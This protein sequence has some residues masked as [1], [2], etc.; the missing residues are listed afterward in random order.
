MLKSHHSIQRVEFSTYYLNSIDLFKA[1]FA[2]TC[3][4]LFEK[5]GIR[6]VKRPKFARYDLNYVNYSDHCG[7][8]II[9]VWTAITNNR[10]GFLA[11]LA[12]RVNGCTYAEILDTFRVNLIKQNFEATNCY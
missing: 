5:N 10:P 7:R 9:S 2:D 4:Y 12:S 6:L 3:C 1:I 8:H 11:R